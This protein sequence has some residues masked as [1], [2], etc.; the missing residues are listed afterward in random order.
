MNPP[1]IPSA[2]SSHSGAHWG[3][4]LVAAAGTFVERFIF[5]GLR[6][7]LL[8]IL[9]KYMPEDR[10][11]G[12]YAAYGA[13]GFLGLILMG[14]VGDLFFE[15][16]MASIL[17]MGLLVMGYLI[18]FLSISLELG[19]PL[20]GLCISALGAGLFRPANIVLML[21]AFPYPDR[22]MVPLYGFYALVNLGAFLGALV[23]TWLLTANL[24]DWAPLIMAALALLWGL[25][26]LLANSM[27]W[28]P[29]E[30]DHQRSATSR[31]SLSPLFG[32][33]GILVGIV[34]I[35]L[36]GLALMQGIGSEM[37]TIFLWVTLA[38]WI[39]GLVMIIVLGR[40]SLLSVFILIVAGGS[41]LLFWSSFE[42]PLGQ[43]SAFA[44]EYEG[45]FSRL[46]ITNLVVVALGS[47]VLGGIFLGIRALGKRPLALS[48]SV[49]TGTW[50]LFL[51][52]M[53]AFGYGSSL[54]SGS[55]YSITILFILL[56]VLE[57][58][59]IPALDFW[60]Y[61]SL[62]GGFRGTGMAMLFGLTFFVRPL[63]GFIVGKE[64]MGASWESIQLAGLNYIPW[65]GAAL[66]LLIAVTVLCWVLPAKSSD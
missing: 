21:N 61:R 36:L 49:V 23:M 34:G 16:K 2:S 3:N 39:A 8:L 19:H 56:S 10:A 25:G 50:V 46:S 20:L 15:R 66:V 26:L 5:Y 35:S 52:L 40:A 32:G 22:G 58:L 54:F 55:Y 42:T 9:V 11:V 65:L 1:P 62:P 41:L 45:G 53:L 13:V 48:G 43:L 24:V 17:G 57:I 31:L 27:G 64:Q 47:L 30:P 14:L 63:S 28:T 59:L 29:S 4:F 12:T 60:V 38:C 6:A 18:M 51:A 44:Y 33:L 7:V 37:S